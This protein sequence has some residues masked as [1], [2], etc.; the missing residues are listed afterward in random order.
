M[1]LALATGG[2]T[3]WAVA[4]IFVTLRD[5]YQVTQGTNIQHA[6]QKYAKY[7]KYDMHEMHSK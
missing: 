4:V 7:K 3:V 6:R 5:F 1:P 2:E